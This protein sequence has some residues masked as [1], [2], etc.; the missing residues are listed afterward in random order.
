M[1]SIKAQAE[2]LYVGKNKIELEAGTGFLSGGLH[3]H[4]G[5]PLR[6]AGRGV[7]LDG[8]LGEMKEVYTIDAS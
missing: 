6:L 8:F 3:Y 1:T 5:G 2:A 7:T 4:G